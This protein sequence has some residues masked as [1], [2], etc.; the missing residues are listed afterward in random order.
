[1]GG[2]G[3]SNLF[4]ILTICLEEVDTEALAIFVVFLVS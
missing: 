2:G 1:M 3:E 4:L